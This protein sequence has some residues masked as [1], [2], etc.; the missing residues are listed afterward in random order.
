[1]GRVA[2][3]KRD[4]FPSRNGKE[5][6]ANKGERESGEGKKICIEKAALHE[7]KVLF[8]FRLKW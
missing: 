1:M 2:G 8:D 3:A 7:P 5:I 4:H 6:M